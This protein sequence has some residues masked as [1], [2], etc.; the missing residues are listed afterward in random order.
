MIKKTS[1]WLAPGKTDTLGFRILFQNLQ[2]NVYLILDASRQNNFVI[3][4][5]SRRHFICSTTVWRSGEFIDRMSAIDR[6]MFCYHKCSQAKLPLPA[7][8]LFARFFD[9]K[10]AINLSALA[11]IPALRQPFFVSC[12]R[13]HRPSLAYAPLY[14]SRVHVFESSSIL[15]IWLHSNR[16]FFS[17]VGLMTF[18][19]ISI[20]KSISDI[21]NESLALVRVDCQSIPFVLLRFIHWLSP[22]SLM[23]H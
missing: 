20:L 8:Y 22:V 16:F 14:R 5:Y 10:Q 7:R 13:W 4:F 19:P 23:I 17:W 3:L 2:H 11:S 12:R 1:C 15:I 6:S 18:L 21:F 9:I